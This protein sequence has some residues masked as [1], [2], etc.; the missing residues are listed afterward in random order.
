MLFPL[1]VCFTSQAFQ[2]Q[3]FTKFWTAGLESI[4][5]QRPSPANGLP[6]GMLHALSQLGKN[7]KSPVTP[8]LSL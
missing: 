8:N 3:V 4:N 7:F 6:A 1:H 5:E 2:K